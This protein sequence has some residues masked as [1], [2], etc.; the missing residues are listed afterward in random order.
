MMN[1]SRLNVP[2]KIYD[3]KNKNKKIL[4]NYVCQTDIYPIIKYLFDKEDKSNVI[5]PYGI[6]N[7]PII[8]ESIFN[9][10]YKVS[11]RTQYHTFHCTCKFIP[12]DFVIMINK[13]L[14]IR[15]E[16]KNDTIIEDQEKLKL[17]YLKIL[18]KHLKKSKIIQIIK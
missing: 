2:L 6:K 7:K 15:I 12:K 17:E 14:D 8:S 4:E 13:K 10:K 1:R 11:I 16:S 5:P 18:D 3:F 9:D